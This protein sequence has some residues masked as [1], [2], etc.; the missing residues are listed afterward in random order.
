MDIN[1]N[2]ISEFVHGFSLV[3]QCDTVSNGMLRFA[4]PFSYPNGSQIDLFLSP[5]KPL[6]GEYILSDYGL[7]SDYLQDLHVKPWATKKR[8]LLIEDICRN[9]GVEQHSG[10]FQIGLSPKELSSLSQAIVR[11][12]Q[13]C[14]RVADLAFTQ[15]LQIAGTFQDEVEEFIAVSDFPYE[16]DVELVGA[17]GQVV[18]V[19]FRVRG[20]KVTSLIQTL[21]TRNPA[22]AH[23]ISNE[24]FRRWYDLRPH[25]HHNQFV[26]IY[27]ASSGIFREDDLARLADFSAVLGYPDD[28]EQIQE[29]LAA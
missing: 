18:K 14:I 16:P 19:D 3:E 5:T 8:R 20:Q 7:T 28:Q 29:A 17:L 6:F 22:N 10:V 1:C 26:T 13:V 27:D 4:T 11:L 9:L 24:V 21:S 12:S 25:L 23:P 2:N 15:R